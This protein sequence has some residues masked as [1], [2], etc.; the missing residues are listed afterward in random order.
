MLAGHVLVEGI[1]AALVRRGI[2]GK[3]A[4]VETSLLEALVDYQFE[5]LTTHLNDGGK[6]PRRAATDNAHAYLGAPYG[7]YRTADG[8]LALAMMP[9]DRLVPLLALARGGDPFTDR[10]ACPSRPDTGR[11]SCRG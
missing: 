1:L 8:W 6:L 5:V 9:L 2:G 11:A 10:E 7:V 3:G 4:L